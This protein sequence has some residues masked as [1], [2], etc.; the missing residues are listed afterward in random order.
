MRKRGEWLGAPPTLTG[1]PRP[2][3]A[4]RSDSPL[5]IPTVAYRGMPALQRHLPP[6]GGERL[7]TGERVRA[8]DADLGDPAAADFRVS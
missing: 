6:G 5:C 3:S 7:G 2:A 4:V 1:S 8:A